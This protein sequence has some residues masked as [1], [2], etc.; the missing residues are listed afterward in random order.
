MTLSDYA[1]DL[2]L[3]GIV[4][5]QLRGRRL[6]VRSLLL[7]V[8]IT[9]WAARTY[10]HSVPTAGNDLVLIAAC[11]AVGVTVGAAAGLLTKVTR[12]ADGTAFARA[13][14]AAA[15][16]WVLGIGLRMGFQEFA[17]HGGAGTI[18][19]FSAAHHIT[20]MQ[21]WVA[22]LILMALAEALTRT[23]VLA[24]RA[25]L[26]LSPRVGAGRAIMGVGEQLA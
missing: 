14:L 6:T 15:A 23:A 4:F 2:A 19:R 17:A 24:G 16:L 1:L 22:A 8:G 26:P 11:T 21:A 25:F 13:G 9:V 18:G 5:L 20:S 3:M 12:G 10:L 7:P